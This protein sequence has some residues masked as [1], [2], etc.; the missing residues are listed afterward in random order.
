MSKVEY[1]KQW[2]FFELLEKLH[3]AEQLLWEYKSV[4]SEEFG[5]AEIFHENLVDA[6]DDI[7]FGNRSDL[8]RF[9]HWFSLGQ[10]WGFFTGEAGKELGESIFSIAE[11][12]K[13]AH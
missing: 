5:L 4:Y 3:E 2:Q 6:I 1:W 9:Y 13:K 7:E 12:W 10:A 8:T 11:R